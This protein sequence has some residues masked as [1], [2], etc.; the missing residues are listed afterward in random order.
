MAKQNRFASV[1]GGLL[2]K[3]LEEGIVLTQEQKAAKEEFEAA[4]EALKGQSKEIENA[5]REA[6]R[7]IDEKAHEKKKEIN[8]RQDML[9]TAYH[10]ELVRLGV[11]EEDIPLIERDVVKTADKGAKVV[12]GGI[13]R[14]VGYISKGIESGVNGE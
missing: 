6:I 11:K 14:F 10:K 2:D 8:E 7:A 12:L 3:V 1:A 13:G 5:R 4:R 9:N